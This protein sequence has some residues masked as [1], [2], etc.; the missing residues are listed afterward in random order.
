MQEELFGWDD[1][2]QLS[3]AD[4]EEQED[5]EDH[6]ILTADSSA[7]MTINEVFLPDWSDSWLLITPVLEPEDENHKMWS[8]S[9]GYG[10]QMR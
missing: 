2:W 4:F 9:F 7:A 6:E 5:D 8:F 1:S 10:Q 3:D